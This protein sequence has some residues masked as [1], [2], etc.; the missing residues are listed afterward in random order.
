[1]RNLTEFFIHYKLMGTMFLDFEDGILKCMIKINCGVPRVPIHRLKRY[2]NAIVHYSTGIGH[3]NVIPLKCQS[4]IDKLRQNL[5]RT[6]NIHIL[7][8]G[9]KKMRKIWD[10]QFR[11]K[12]EEAKVAL[13]HGKFS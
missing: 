11:K 1:M 3:S 6:L 12:L 9:W 10:F 13:K 8:I 7:L 2:N 5:T 4:N